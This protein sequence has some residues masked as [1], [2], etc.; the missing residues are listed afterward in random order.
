MNPAEVARKAATIMSERGHCKHT[1]E[2][3]EG[4]V[5]YAGAIAIAI[6]GR[7][8][9]QGTPEEGVLYVAVND[10]AQKILI[11]RGYETDYS[12]IG[13]FIQRDPVAFNNDERIT[14][15]DVISLLKETAE[16]LEEVQS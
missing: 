13:S 4:R 16:K 12:Y 5:C 3:E 7:S 1:L 6:N 15:E 8:R 14:G 9:W 2:D 11:E 10:E